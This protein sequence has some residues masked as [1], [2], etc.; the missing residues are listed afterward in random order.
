MEPALP[1]LFSAVAPSSG[2]RD[3]GGRLAALDRAGLLGPDLAQTLAALTELAAEVIGVPVALVSLVTDDRQVFV[4]SHGLPEPWGSRGQTG[5]SHSFCRLVVEDDAP[6][7]IADARLNPRTAGNLAIDDIGVIAYAGM[8]LRDPDGQVLG[9]VCAITDRPHHWTEREL[10]LLQGFNTVVAALVADRVDMF[11]GAR[12]Q[13]RDAAQTDRLSRRLQRALLPIGLEDGSADRTVVAYQP[14]SERLLLGGD[15]CDVLHHPSGDLGFVIGDI[16]G[17]GPE[18]AA[19][20]IGLRSSWAALESDSPSLDQLAARLNLIALREQRGDG[21]MFASLILGRLCV[22][23]SASRA[24]SAG[25]PAP[26]NLGDVSEIALPAGPLIGLF[27]DACWT[28]A[29]LP[30]LPLGMLAYTDGLIEGRAA[31]GESERWG[32]NRLRATVRA[33]QGSDQPRAELPAA[34]ISAATAAHGDE[35]P[36]DVAILIVR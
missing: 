29:P 31:P 18:S 6:L 15:F 3:D 35:L 5:L 32:A 23:A 19:M 36:D 33:Q 14:G 11:T 16:C 21:S 28:S 8:P 27:A 10:E 26:I 1:G 2:R 20:A 30:P 34:L 17:H 9:S 13:L 12:E 7:V 4:G 25:H 22:D 24:L